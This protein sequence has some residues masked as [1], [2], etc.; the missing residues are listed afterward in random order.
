MSDM[1]QDENMSF[2]LNGTTQAVG[3]DNNPVT[4]F[5]DQCYAEPLTID[6]NKTVINAPVAFQYRF[7]SL[8]SNGS[9]IRTITGDMNNTSS[10]L[11]ST[12]DFPKALNGVANTQLNLNFN[13]SVDTAINPQ[14]IRFTKYDV[15]CTTA[16][17]CSFDANLLTNQVAQGSKDLNATIKY[18]Y[19]RTHAK[20]QRFVNNT[21]DV[22]IYYE[23]YCQGGTCDKSLLQDGADSNSTDDPRWFINTKH[24]TVFGDTGS[25]TQKTTGATRVTATTPSTA[26]PAITTLTYDGNSGYPYKATMENNSSTWLI[27]NPYNNTATTNEFSVEFTK[28]GTPWRGQH[29]TNTTTTTNATDRTNRRTMW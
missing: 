12:A 11:M 27:Y 10:I 20:R 25:V 28:A 3:Y 5:V 21:G 24:T 22:K 1:S 29:E 9:I 14:E 18:Y 6:L 13:R 17:N 15:N 8:D 4:N 7:H 19:G 23:V 2:H 26:S 16:A